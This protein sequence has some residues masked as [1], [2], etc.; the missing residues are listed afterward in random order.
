MGRARLSRQVRAASR[1]VCK[2]SC[3]PRQTLGS[4]RAS[5]S[6]C[7][8]A[9]SVSVSLVMLLPPNEA[10]PGEARLFGMTTVGWGGPLDAFAGHSQGA[11]R[12]RS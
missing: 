6:E 4:E 11:C 8:G 1:P 10:L 2:V 9:Y 3:I 5:Y 7:R 12:S